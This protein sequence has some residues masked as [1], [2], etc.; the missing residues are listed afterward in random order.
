MLNGLV[1]SGHFVDCG[2]NVRSERV[3]ECFAAAWAG[4]AEELM[5]PCT[6]LLDLVFCDSVQC[7]SRSA[8]RVPLD[9]S[10]STRHEVSEKIFGRR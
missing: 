7:G 4:W 2:G 1:D 3:I 9:E 10:C 6:E 5:A 8:K